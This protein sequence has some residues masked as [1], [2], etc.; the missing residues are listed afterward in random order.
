MMISMILACSVL[1]GL[2]D[3]TQGQTDGQTPR[4]WLRGTKHSCRT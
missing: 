3:V 1:I 2:K 4:L